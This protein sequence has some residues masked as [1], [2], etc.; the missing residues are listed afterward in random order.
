[1]RFFFFVRVKPTPHLRLGV[2]VSALLRVPPF[3]APVGVAGPATADSR[4]SEKAD[5]S[6]LVDRVVPPWTKTATLSSAQAMTGRDGSMPGL[7][8][9]G[10]E[11]RKRARGAIFLHGDR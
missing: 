2:D 6:P 9:R 3:A 7:A 11:N 4:L 1:M 10:G 5:A 8:R